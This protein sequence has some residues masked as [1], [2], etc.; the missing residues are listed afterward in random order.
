MN[1]I[2]IDNWLAQEAILNEYTFK[3]ELSLNYQKLLSA[4]VLWDEI[5]YP[6]NEKSI[7]WKMINNS[8]IN[9]FLKPLEDYK[10]LFEYEANSIYIENYQKL[11]RRLIAKEGIR[12]LLLSNYQGFDYVPSSARNLFFER[13][14]PYNI[15]N[16]LNRFDF[17]KTLDKEIVD[18]FDELNSKFGRNVFEIQRPVL[19]DFIIQNTPKSMSYIEFAL[20][21]REEKSVIQYRKYLTEL[22]N[23][24][25]NRE[26]KKLQELFEISSEVVHNAVKLDKKSI[27]TIEFSFSALPALNFSKEI[28]IS[29]RKIHLTFLDKLS[30]FAFDGR[31]MY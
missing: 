1:A 7:Q 11:E 22:E 14:N 25:E 21:L 9:I 20:K 12:Y 18:Y 17:I 16:K 27:G 6:L 4:I 5:Y 30:E 26:W 2:M 19:V 15:L 28:E 10:R 24:L 29:K 13:Y 8:E 31:K 3:D 23:S